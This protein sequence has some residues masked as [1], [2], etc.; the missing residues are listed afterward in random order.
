MGRKQYLFHTTTP[1]NAK[2]ILR[3]GLKRENGFCCYLSERPFSWWKPGMV[4]LRIRIT[5][6]KDLHVSPEEGLDE[7]LSFEDI[8][9][10]RIHEYKPTRKELLQGYEN[11]YNH[12]REVT[13]MMDKADKEAGE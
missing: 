4:I 3:E 6:L 7:I 10:L 2:H 5:G 9:P 8:S 12:F 13:K 11:F 1:E